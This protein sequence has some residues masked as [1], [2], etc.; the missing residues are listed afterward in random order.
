M[1]I[2]MVPEEGDTTYT[3][4]C[5][6]VSELSAVRLPLDRR[7]SET[8]SKKTGERFGKATQSRDFFMMTIRLQDR[9]AAGRILNLFKE[10]V[11]GL[12]LPCV[13]AGGYE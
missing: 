5:S 13:R 4:L 11:R 12:G 6:F 10:G 9:A 1:F 2:P 7:L 8:F 3:L